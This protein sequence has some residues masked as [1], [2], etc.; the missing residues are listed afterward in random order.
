MSGAEG[1]G[2]G[3]AVNDDDLD[4]KYDE[5]FAANQLATFLKSIDRQSI[6]LRH[7]KDAPLVINHLLSGGESFVC[8]VLAQKIKEDDGEEENH[9]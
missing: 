3:N 9:E 2:F 8:L 7:E 6:T 4:T 1:L 5:M